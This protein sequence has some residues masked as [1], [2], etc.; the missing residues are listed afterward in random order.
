MEQEDE[1][2]EEKDY[3][4]PS[5]ETE[6]GGRDVVVGTWRR[7]VE[8]EGEGLPERGG[9]DAV[10]VLDDGG[11][12]VAIAV[13][14]VER[15]NNRVNDGLARVESGGGRNPRP[16]EGLDRAAHA[17]GGG[18]V[19]LDR[20]E[21]G[22]PVG[23]VERNLRVRVIRLGVRERKIGLGLGTTEGSGRGVVGPCRILG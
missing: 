3:T 20:V 18:P 14:I 5:S 12:R 8:I 13:A 7:E 9:E 10:L 21:L 19:H 15:R 16:A 6:R 22:E 17:A 2:E 23:L 11:R 4:D 1:D